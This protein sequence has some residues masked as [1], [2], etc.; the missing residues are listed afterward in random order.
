MCR[1]FEEMMAVTYHKFNNINIASKDSTLG[2]FYFGGLIA[3]PRKPAKPCGY[4]LFE[5]DLEV[6]RLLSGFQ[7]L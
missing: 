1:T 6:R 4:H 7:D 5:R 3:M 2:A